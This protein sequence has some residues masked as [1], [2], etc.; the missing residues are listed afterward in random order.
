MENKTRPTATPVPDFLD[1]LDTRR[2]GEAEE[3]IV[4]MREISGEDPVMWGPSI[5]G[6]GSTS[7]RLA[8]GREGEMGLLSFSPRRSAI[9]VYIPEG[10]ERHGDLLDR[11]GKH[12]TGVSCLYLNKLVDVDAEVLRELVQRS[13]QHHAE[14]PPAKPT[15]VDEYLASVPQ[16]A[17]PQLDELR[18]LVREV[19]PDAQEVLSYDIIGYR[20]A[21]TKRAYGF[22][23]GWRDH[24]GV[25]PVPKDS[26][27]EAEL[28][29]YRRGKGTLWFPLEEP[30]PREL[31]AR[32]F[33]AL[34]T[35]GG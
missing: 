28:T 4:M 27:L 33:A 32:V 23:S 1:G 29:T 35:T 12:R 3:L 8:S 6:F 10:F 19:A 5:I 11:L 7:Y 13:F 9:T 14:P 26:A 34:L 21:G 24:I 22:I 20:P 31:L 16:A 30:L 17:R 2:R 18:A 15:T 25:Y